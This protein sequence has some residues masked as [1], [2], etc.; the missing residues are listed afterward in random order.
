MIDG[1]IGRKRGMTQIYTETGDAI[2]V[3]VVEVGPCPVI[4]VK[5]PKTDGYT[6]VQVGFDNITKKALPKAV[7]EKYKVLADV[8]K[9]VAGQEKFEL[10]PQ[11]VL[12]EFKPLNAE[13]LPALGQ[14]LDVS[15][16][17]GVT[18]IRVTGTS[19]GKGFQGVMFRHNFGGGG[20]A[21]GSCFHRRPGAIGCRAFPGKIHKGKRMGGHMGHR[22]IT[23]RGLTIA[24][25]NK[26]LNLLYIRGAVPGPINGFVTIRRMNEVVK[27]ASKK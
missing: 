7:R 25:V 19:K 18:L 8:V 6:A 12:K 4:Q 5:T 3:T 26:E 16:L 27:S 20:A 13:A 9:K 22:Q 11:R 15:V 24:K 23:T 1:L 14:V 2:P 10:K 21:H 17:D